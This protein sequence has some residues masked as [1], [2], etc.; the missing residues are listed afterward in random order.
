[1][2]F[3]DFL[4]P[5][6]STVSNAI[7]NAIASVSNVASNTYNAISG[8]ASSAANAASS[9]AGA[10]SSAANQYISPVVESASPAISSG[11]SYISSPVATTVSNAIGSIT[12][13]A[14][15][16]QLQ[17]SFNPVEVTTGFV[18]SIPNAISSFE[19][20]IPLTTISAPTM[21]TASQAIKQ[22]SKFAPSVVISSVAPSI[23]IGLGALGVLTSSNQPTVAKITTGITGGADYSGIISTAPSS[24]LPVTSPDGTVTFYTPYGNKAQTEVEKV[25]VGVDKYG[26]VEAYQKPYGHSIYNLV[27]SGSTGAAQSGMFTVGKAETPVTY[28]Q[29]SAGTK[30]APSANIIEAK[31][32]ISSPEKYSNLGA[33]VYGGYVRPLTGATVESSGAKLSTYDNPLNLANLVNP[34]AVNT[35]KS[36]MVFSDIPWSVPENTPA[37]FRLG[38]SGVEGAA[39]ISPTMASVITTTPTVTSVE[40]PTPFKSTV[41]SIKKDTG[42][43]G[44]LS[45]TISNVDNAIAD[46]LGM[47]TSAATPATGGND[48]FKEAVS[49]VGVSKTTAASPSSPTDWLGNLYKVAESVPMVGTGFFGLAAPIIGGSLALGETLIQTSQRASSPEVASKTYTIRNDLPAVLGEAGLAAGDAL[50]TLPSSLTGGLIP[51][52][53]PGAD[54]LAKYGQSGTSASKD[55]TAQMTALNA[56]QPQIDALGSKINQEQSDINVFLSGK[57]DSGGKFIGSKEDY[58]KYQDMYS[59]LD[60]DVSQY[61]EYNIKYQDVLSG[62]YKSGAIISTGD[63]GYQ[64]APSSERTYGAFS[65]WAN[66]AQKLLTGATPEQFATFERSSEFKNAESYVPKWVGESATLI[67][68]MGTLGL[69]ANETVFTPQFGEGVYKTIT[70][71]QEVLRS[72][73]QGVGLYALTGGAGE[74]LGALGES[75]GTVG[76]V[77]QLGTSAFNSPWVQGG[78]G[79]LFAGAGINSAAGGFDVGA[80]GLTPKVG[81]AQFRSNLGQ[82]G[83]NLYIMGVGAALPDIGA[84]LFGS[85][86]VTPPSGGSALPLSPIDTGFK[87]T[88]RE[89][90]LTSKLGEGEIDLNQFNTFTGGKRSVGVEPVAPISGEGLALPEPSGAVRAVSTPSSSL[91]TDI[92]IPSTKPTIITG[93]PAY[94][95]VGNIQKGVKSKG[96]VSDIFTGEPLFPQVPKGKTRIGHVANATPEL[97]RSI[98]ERGLAAYT[99]PGEPFSGLE[100]TSVDLTGQGILFPSAKNANPKEWLKATQ[101][102]YLEALADRGNQFGNYERFGNDIFIF[103]VDPNMYNLPETIPSAGNIYTGKE[104]FV[105]I[106]TRD[107]LSKMSRVTEE[108]ALAQTQPMKRVATQEEQVLAQ[109]KPTK[110]A[111]TE[112]ELRSSLGIGKGG[113][114]EKIYSG[115]QLLVKGTNTPEPRLRLNEDMEPHQLSLEAS[116]TPGVFAGIGKGF[117]LRQVEIFKPSDYLNEKVTT[118]WT[119]ATLETTPWYS[120]KAGYADFVAKWAARNI[121]EQGVVSTPRTIEELGTSYKVE[122][123]KANV[124]AYG[125]IFV[126]KETKLLDIGE[127][128]VFGNVGTVT[129]KSSAEAYGINMDQYDAITGRATRGKGTSG[130]T[131]VTKYTTTKE[132]YPLTGEVRTF[133]MGKR[134][135][136]ETPGRIFSY[137]KEPSAIQ[138]IKSYEEILQGPA[139]ASQKEIAP[140]T[141]KELASAT[142][143]YG[144]SLSEILPEQIVKNVE[145]V[146]RTPQS[147]ALTLKTGGVEEKGLPGVGV[148]TAFSPEKATISDYLQSGQMEKEALGR[149]LLEVGK[150]QTISK[151]GSRE[152]SFDVSLPEEG[153]KISPTEEIFGL[154]FGKARNSVGAAVDALDLSIIPRDT[155]ESRKVKT[156]AKEKEAT[157]YP[158]FLGGETKKLVARQVV[159]GAPTAKKPTLSKPTPGVSKPSSAILK[160]VEDSQAKINSIYSAIEKAISKGEQKTYTTQEPSLGLQFQEPSRDLSPGSNNL[161][162]SSNLMGVSWARRRPVVIEEEEVVYRRDIPG[163]KRPSAQTQEARLESLVKPKVITILGTSIGQSIKSKQDNISLQ[164]LKVAQRSDVVRI[165]DTLRDLGQASVTDQMKEAVQRS[166][167]KRDQEQN[168]KREFDWITDVVPRT[169]LRQK[170][171]TKQ[172]II[173]LPNFVKPPEIVPEQ[174]EPSKDKTEPPALPILPLGGQFGTGGGTGSAAGGPGKKHREVFQYNFNWQTNT[175]LGGKNVKTGGKPS[176]IGI[177][178]PNIGLEASRKPSGGNLRLN[179][180]T[181]GKGLVSPKKTVI[182]SSNPSKNV[183]SSLPKSLKAPEAAREPVKKSVS[184]GSTLPKSL[185]LGS[186]L[187]QKKKGKK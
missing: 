60:S 134:A 171:E 93:E 24:S 158:R 175:A 116:T 115:D 44:Q 132:T 144:T 87:M 41:S 105:G 129:R 25:K 100:V 30:F 152:Y 145:S 82:M 92:V 46:F 110:R 126:Q 159:G 71:P 65:D 166:E 155:F 90:A 38:A 143:V 124:P 21:E 48:L 122:T 47:R 59:K 106:I 6:T 16:Q 168:Y 167:Q 157:Y 163:M 139:K 182:E 177:N 101:K 13:P 140:F 170:V 31:Q 103:D 36:Q 78:I 86:R 104:S 112:E 52:W 135:T 130:Q 67:P 186:S 83:A 147:E 118:D 3:L 128:D 185:G 176:S 43:V 150:K 183:R 23:G 22:V 160:S 169:T 187:P 133:R 88:P 79:A 66:S 114:Q 70:N 117:G 27:S 108:Q 137:L 9:A 51:S 153:K 120:T 5:I 55:F 99:I 180:P 142:S 57:I 7:S 148:G 73:I 32:V 165:S 61:N 42:I 97:V 179:T 68:G 35:P 39:Q 64:T 173:Q 14:T 34:Q 56:Q 111:A 91:T 174:K 11:I 184:S 121:K 95:T 58:T 4:T 19:R 20:Q 151:I 156:I 12:S 146:I 45:D 63:G 109:I 80:G 76:K 178:I 138:Q 131:I 72:G 74:V 49:T 2:G 136:S 161:A 127:P 89:Y 84:G 53:T 102:T 162:P 18:S 54:L 154:A 172:D 98:Q 164:S 17:S 37:I 10:V 50:T 40:L 26:N 15:Y 8:A 113:V 1:M 28:T 94:V 181:F 107:Q 77:A 119:G 125:D 149:T 141:G 75:S 62:G 123:T 81:E 96:V 33:E 29:E 85:A 69:V